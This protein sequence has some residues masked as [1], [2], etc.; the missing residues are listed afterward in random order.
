MRKLLALLFLV[1][2]TTAASATT[3]E[4]ESVSVNLDSKEVDVELE[5]Q[6]LTSSRLTYFT[7]HEITDLSVT[8]NG[9]PLEC[10]VYSSE[11]NNQISCE[12]D[13]KNNFTAVIE[14]SSPGIV[15]SQGETNTFETTE[16]FIR[17]TRNY[18][19]EVRL[20][21]GNILATSNETE[22]VVEPAGAEISTDGQ[23][24]TVKWNDEPELGSSQTY[25]VIYQ[26][27][28]RTG[29][30]LLE[31]LGAAVV[32]VTALIL[33]YFAL[34][35]LREEELDSVYGELE[36]DE[37]EVLDLLKENE[38]SMLQKDLVEQLDYSKAKISGTVS[39]LVER[40]IIE[41]Q[42]EGRSNRVSIRKNYRY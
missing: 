24:I 41:K 7:D 12:T 22:S 16:S 11:T 36:E 42:K 9:E 32:I 28:G 35:K 30:Q 17:P 40:E 19:L 29:N 26:S 21:E 20:P 4:H 14:Y 38:G 18:S 33:G 10:Q 15:E 39:S 3:I 25:R 5:V 37:K 2:L 27:A 8:V 1:M 31:R 23:R 13:V 6:E 34:K